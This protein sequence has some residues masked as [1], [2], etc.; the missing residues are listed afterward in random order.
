MRGPNR[1]PRGYYPNK[2]GLKQQYICHVSADISEEDNNWINEFAKS[3]NITRAEVIR[4]CIRGSKLI[5]DILKT[6]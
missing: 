4:R 3:H 2:K 6:K 5:T 1:M